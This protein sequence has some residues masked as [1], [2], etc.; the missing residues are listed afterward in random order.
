MDAMGAMLGP[1][2]A[3]VILTA[4]PG[5]FDVVFVTSFL[6]ALIGLAVLALFVENRS[7]GA[8]QTSAAGDGRCRVATASALLTFAI[9]SSARSC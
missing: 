8:R 9:W 2:L 1:I 6:V 3:F 5:A 7:A 4:L